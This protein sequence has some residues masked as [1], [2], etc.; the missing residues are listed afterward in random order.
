VRDKQ[1]QDRREELE[2]DQVEDLQVSDDAAEQVKGGETVNKA[3]T[4]DKA[5]KA[6]NDYIR[7]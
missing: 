4:A 7:G 1:E 2:K 6:I 3:K 5:A